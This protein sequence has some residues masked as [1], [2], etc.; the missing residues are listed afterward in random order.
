MLTPCL[1]FI[2]VAMELTWAGPICDSE[3]CPLFSLLCC[4]EAPFPASSAHCTRPGNP[5]CAFGQPKEESS[6][7]AE[8]LRLCSDLGDIMNN[9]EF[10]VFHPK[11]SSCGEGC[12]GHGQGKA[13]GTEPRGRLSNGHRPLVGR[14]ARR[15]RKARHSRQSRSLMKVETTLRPP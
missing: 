13:V 12:W 14:E 5:Q 8:E 2:W 10:C 9:L 15:G 3:H 1:C 11:E 4:Q 7:A 6:L